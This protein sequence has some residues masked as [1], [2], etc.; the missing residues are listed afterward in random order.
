M[1]FKKIR[2]GDLLIKQGLRNKELEGDEPLGV[3]I[4]KEFMPSVANT[5][6][7]DLSKY[8]LLKRDFFACNPMHVGRDRA[9][10]IA[11]YKRDEPGIVSPAYFTFSVDSSLIN[12]D[13]LELLFKQNNF[14]RECWFYTD[15]TVR[16]GLSWEALCDIEV[17]VPSKKEQETI[18][19]ISKTIARRIKALNRINDYLAA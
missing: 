18:A 9:L 5:I 16:G 15:S 17:D 12:L 2:L 14:D 7:T 11:R 1:G 3:S 10:P 19:F 8:M 4:D 13:Y 6:G